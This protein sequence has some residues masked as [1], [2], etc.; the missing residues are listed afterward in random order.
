MALTDR[1]V[2]NDVALN[3]DLYELTMA[4]GFWESGLVDAQ[5]CFNVFF[6]DNPFN[7]GYAVACGIGQIAELV[8]NL[9]FDDESIAYL[10]SVKAPGGGPLFKQGFLDYLRDFRMHVD[11]WA[12]PEGTPVFP[13]EPL[14][15]VRAP[16]IEAQLGIMMSEQEW[17]IEGTA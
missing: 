2:P 9:R 14:L 8:E 15:T 13:G 16:L 7:G 6:R 17:I 3:T 1:T 12:I 10:A 5:G 11:I 4:Q